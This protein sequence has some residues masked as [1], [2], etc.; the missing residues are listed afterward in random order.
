[1]Q[2]RQEQIS[3]PQRSTWCS[4]LN[5]LSLRVRVG[6]SRGLAF[7]VGE[8]WRIRCIHAGGRRKGAGDSTQDDPTGLP[9]A[10][11][12]CCFFE[13]IGCR[14]G[15]LARGP[16][17]RLKQPS[18]GAF[19]EQC[20]QQAPKCLDRNGINKNRDRLT[21]LPFAFTAGSNGTRR[22]A[23]SKKPG[24]YRRGPTCERTLPPSRRLMLQE[25]L[26]LPAVCCAAL[27]KLAT[28]ASVISTA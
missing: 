1:M 5:L 28:L 11:L 19:N 27:V 7:E 3:L 18:V 17:P 16:R 25:T 13:I 4:Y 15:L 21:F 23:C 2:R 24:R 12:A 8:P 22:F 9:A 26:R 6:P 20:A 14:S 10:D